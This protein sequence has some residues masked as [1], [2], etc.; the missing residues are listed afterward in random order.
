MTPGE[1]M[2]RFWS[3]FS[4]RDLAP[5]LIAVFCTFVA[6]GFLRDI[7]ELGRFTRSYLTFIAINTGLMAV[8]YAL[9]M[10][11]NPR[12]WLPVVLL[13]QLS[14]EYLGRH[15]FGLVT[16][17]LSMADLAAR[18]G[19]MGLSASLPYFWGTSG[20][21]ASSPIK[22]CVACALIP[23]WS[24]PARSMRCWLRQSTAERQVLRLWVRRFLPMKW[25]GTSSTPFGLTVD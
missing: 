11:R 4:L 24:W 7:Q 25:A 6:F 8:G 5:F 20:S 10:A 14:M 16:S 12:R 19:S 21:S 9:A 18:L 1:Q 23:R 3:R 13:L 15:F 2:R 22:A 17:P